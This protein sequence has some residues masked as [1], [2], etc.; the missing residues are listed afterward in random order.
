MRAFSAENT[1]AS[2][3]NHICMDSPK[4]TMTTKKKTSLSWC[5]QKDTSCAPHINQLSQYSSG[6]DGSSN[7]IS[8]GNK[9]DEGDSKYSD[10]HF[11]PWLFTCILEVAL[12]SRRNMG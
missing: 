1:K 5:L 11:F 6:R 10:L 8:L 3:V 12:L 9:G 7:K 4:Y 2:F